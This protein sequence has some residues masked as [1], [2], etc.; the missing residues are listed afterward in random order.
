MVGWRISASRDNEEHE[1]ALGHALNS[2]VSVVSVR[3]GGGLMEDR[4][5]KGKEMS[6][7]VGPIRLRREPTAG[8]GT[9]LKIFIC[10]ICINYQYILV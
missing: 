7:H 4:E 5:R 3:S 8:T 1:R 2:C 10:L 9:Q 6:F